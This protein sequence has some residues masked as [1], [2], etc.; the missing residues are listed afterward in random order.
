[1]YLFIAR[2]LLC[3][4]FNVYIFSVLGGFGTFHCLLNAFVHVVMYFYYGLSVLG[5]KYQKHLWWKR[6]VTVLQ[7]VSSC[8]K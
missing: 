7:L 5:P 3:D 1:M 4:A 8:V 2:L 6:Y